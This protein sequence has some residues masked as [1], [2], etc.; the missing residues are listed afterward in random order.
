MQPLYVRLAS[1]HAG[2]LAEPQ[3]EERGHI[4]MGDVS[5]LLIYAIWKVE[6]IHV[7]EQLEKPLRLRAGEG[8]HCLGYR[9]DRV[10]AQPAGAVNKLL[11]AEDHVHHIRYT[12]QL[13]EHN[14]PID[15]E[16]KGI[17]QGPRWI[18]GDDPKYEYSLDAKWDDRE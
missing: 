3:D 4:P 1:E 10:A 12:P 5:L 7:V 15:G 14:G 9:K 11:E 8:P 2:S 13:E 17:R 18:C 6:L 16:E